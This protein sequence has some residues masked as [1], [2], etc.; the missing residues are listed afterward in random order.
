[1]I[2][3]APKTNIDFTKFYSPINCV[4]I[5]DLLINKDYERFL[6]ELGMVDF[7]TIWQLKGDKIIKKIP[8]RSVV[9]IQCEYQG[10]RR[11]FY[12]KRHKEK[13]SRNW[14]FAHHNPMRL[15]SHGITEYENICEFR[16]HGLETVIPVV[17]GEKHGGSTQSYL[18]SFLMTE[19]F[20]PFFS[21]ERMLFSTPEFFTGPH[22]K[23][24]KRL[25]LKKIA[26]YAR[27][28]HCAGFNH[29]DFNTDHILLYYSNFSKAPEIAMYDFQRADRRRYLKAKW[30]IKAMAEFNYSLPDDLFGPDSRC[31]LFLT[32]KGKKEYELKDRLQHLLIRHKAKQISRHTEKINRRKGGSK[33]P[34]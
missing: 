12:L 32:Y 8:K 26:Q 30:T 1:M 24:R 22:G 21:L 20:S 13:Q 2:K 9:R 27:K 23:L 5:E 29:M 19:D 25:L 18:E 7:E 4:K 16:E 28:M 17:A 34:Q 10:R 33:K 6:H 15:S 3:V 14:L 31:Y 11:T